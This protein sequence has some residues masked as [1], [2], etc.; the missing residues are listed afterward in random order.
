MVPYGDPLLWY[1]E[2]RLEEFRKEA[3]RQREARRLLA[4]R[5]APRSR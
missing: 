1:T 3:A 2:E 5:P 4:G